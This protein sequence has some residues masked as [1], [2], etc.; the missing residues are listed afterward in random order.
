MVRLVDPVVDRLVGENTH[1]DSAGRPEQLKVTAPVKPS[2]STIE[3]V[4][5]PELPGAWIGNAVV[6]SSSE[7]SG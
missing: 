5:E 2:K 1:A 7:K 3:I 6:D 4:I